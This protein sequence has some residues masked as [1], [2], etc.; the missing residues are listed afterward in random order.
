MTARLAPFFVA[1]SFLIG[2]AGQLPAD[3]PRDQ[4]P[5]VSRIHR[6][7]VDSDAIAAIG[8][9]PRLHALEIE[10]KRGGTY[11][12]VQVPRSIHR[13]LMAAESKAGFYNRHVRGKFRSLHVRE[14]RQ[15]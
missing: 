8:Y 6:E 14:R 12:Y 3:E 5:I 9:S 4:R 15:K 11:R 13:E 1:L 10:F 7:A 2:A